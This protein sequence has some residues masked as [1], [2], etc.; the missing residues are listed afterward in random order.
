M[1]ITL[2][3][4]S[5]VIGLCAMVTLTINVLLGMLLSTGY[6]AKAWWKNL[7][8][9]VKKINILLL[10][11]WTAYLALFLVMLHPAL[12]LFDRDAKFTLADIVFPLH[13]PHQKIFVAF[14]TLAMFALIAVVITTQ[15]IIKKKMSFRLWK[16]IHLISYGTAMLFIVHGL[17]MDPQ[18]KDRPTDWLDGEKILCEI[19]LVLLIAATWLR[20]KYNFKRSGI[21]VR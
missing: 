20:L 12:L 21:P 6:K 16:N 19:C 1:D 11:N 13:A 18:L 2:I 15:K 10:H 3:D 5:S 9:I 4:I 17:K 14:G 8:G 7:P